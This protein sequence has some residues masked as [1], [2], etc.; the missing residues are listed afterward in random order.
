MNLFENKSS[1]VECNRR[2]RFKRYVYD[3]QYDN[4]G[5][6][7]QVLYNMGYVRE[8]ES[9]GTDWDI[10]LS[11]TYPF[12]IVPEKR[13]LKNALPHQ[14]INHIPG[15]HHLTHKGSF[16]K[17]LSNHKFLLPTFRMTEHKQQ[18]LDF[19]AEYPDKVLVQKSIYHYGTKI[20]KVK[21]MNLDGSL[22]LVQEYLQ[23]PLLVEGHK[24]DIGV[25]VV[26]TSIDPLRIYVYNSEVFLR[27][28][29]I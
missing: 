27:Y 2:L 5:E 6:A 10:F 17:G 23:K 4:A 7:N 13:E 11:R 16:I 21:D 9:N 26:I 1:P 28:V 14:R 24:C 15:I 12:D 19:I 22:V 20:M 25:Y 18:L 8:W 3:S 29:Q